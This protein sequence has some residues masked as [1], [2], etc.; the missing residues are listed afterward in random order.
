MKD[1]KLV[2]ATHNENKVKEVQAILPPHI[3]LLSLTDIGCLEEIPETGKTLEENAILK[4]NYIT[5]KFSYPC[6]ADDTG[7]VV[8]ALDGAPGVYSARYAGESRD[9]NANMSKLLNELSHTKDRAARFET[10]IA[11][12]LNNEQYIFTGKVEGEITDKKSGEKGF[13]YDPIFK[14]L[15]YTKTFAEL[16]LEVKNKIGHRGKAIQKL[17]LHLK[18]LAH[19][20]E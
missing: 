14:P 7:L 17:I 4:A 19:I 6:F 16:P 2:F 20:T 15:G 1:M 10:V 11:L 5:Q 8:D 12:N 13:G 9:A 3:S 18:S